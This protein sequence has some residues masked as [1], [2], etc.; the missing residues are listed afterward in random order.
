MEEKIEELRNS[1]KSNTNLTEE[2]KCNLGTLSDTLVTVFPMYDYS[3]FNKVLSTLN[4][5]M[6]NELESYSNYNT[7]DNTLYINTDKCFIDRID[8]QHL[9]LNELL[10]ISTKKYENN[11]ELNGFDTGL[12]EIISST[13]NNDESMKKQNVLESTL[14]SIFSKIVS[15][16]TLLTSYM[17]NDYSGIVLELESIGVE[18]F[19]FDELIRAFNNASDFAKAENI[20]TNMY[21]K[22]VEKSIENGVITKEDINYEYSNYEAMLIYSNSELSAMYPHHDFT[23]IKDLN[24]VKDTLD[25]V[26]V[27]TENKELERVK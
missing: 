5:K 4:I 12:T 26:V 8:L 20:M 6:N 18:K 10:K 22:K 11:S 19:E 14:M 15:A 16:D 3:N 27:N 2:F 9:F 1:I 24:T 23:V 21:S 13:I 7:N 25:K 17:N